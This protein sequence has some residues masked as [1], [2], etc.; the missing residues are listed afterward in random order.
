MFPEIAVGLLAV[1]FI[2]FVTY[3]WDKDSARIGER[4]VSEG[5][6]LFLALIGGSI[7]AVIAQQWLRHKT[8]KEPF[9]TIL[10][11]IFMMQ[12]IV[13]A[14]VS[15]AP[16]RNLVVAALHTGSTILT[17]LRHGR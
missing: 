11:S 17:D 9:R 8:R 5:T 1:N 7:G 13:V 16:A 10:L 4:R 14:T 3:A 6:L 12:M 2:A 15:Y